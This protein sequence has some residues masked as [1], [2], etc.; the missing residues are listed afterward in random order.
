LIYLALSVTLCVAPAAVI[1]ADTDAASEASRAWPGPGRPHLP[2]SALVTVVP[3]RLT[4]QPDTGFILLSVEI[5]GHPGTVLLDT[6][7]PFFYLNRQ[8]MPPDHVG[9]SV[10]AITQSGESVV[11]WFVHT[12]HIGT[13]VQHYD[14]TRAETPL[15]PGQ[16]V[17]V[18]AVIVS[19]AQD[20]RLQQFGRP[21]LAFLGL[22]A[23]APFETII[24]YAHQ[25]LL[26]IRLD[27]AGHRL[28]PVPGYTP[29]TTLP[30][31]LLHQQYYGVAVEAGGR[32]GNLIID[33]GAPENSINASTQHGL[34]SHL[35][36]TGRTDV[37][38][39]PLLLL[40]SL[41]VDGHAYPAVPFSAQGASTRIP[42]SLLGYP[43]L[44]LLSQQGAVGFNLRAHQLVVYHPS[45]GT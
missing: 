4:T 16:P 1:W 28:A 39:H 18:N 17:G 3:F 42:Y 44:K 10:G 12:L 36:G 15:A 6:G 32:H 37:W 22:P 29:T 33:T 7:C 2:D 43:F 26:L 14:S 25:R 45:S 27:A 35:T 23:L 11:P 38:D 30:L 24:D 41:A 31:S 9:P 21:I 34:G 13:L 8:Y 19:A 20:E 40:D 5:D